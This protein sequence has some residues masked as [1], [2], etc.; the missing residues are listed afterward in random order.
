MPRSVAAALGPQSLGHERDIVTVKLDALLLP[1][2]N[3][4]PSLLNGHM[5]RCMHPASNC[6]VHLA[7]CTFE[8]LQQLEGAVGILIAAGSP[9]QRHVILSVELGRE[10][11][12]LLR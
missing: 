8:L 1:L 4:A 3:G 5:R 12:E 10:A 7:T 2:V 9:D 6:Y 11:R